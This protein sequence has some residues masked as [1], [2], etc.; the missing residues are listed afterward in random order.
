MK[1][2]EVRETL[3]QHQRRTVA[4]PEDL[5]RRA[6]TSSP[7]TS[8]HCVTS[9]LNSSPGWSFRSTIRANTISTVSGPL[10]HPASSCSPQDCEG[11]LNSAASTATARAP[12]SPGEEPF[13]ETALIIPLKPVGEFDH[14]N[15][16]L[17]ELHLYTNGT[18]LGPCLHSN[19]LRRRSRMPG[20]PG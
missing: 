4:L 5:S 2:N 1:S 8:L 14:P 13:A 18:Y 17:L 11:T 9:G 3:Q 6:N 15:D 20:A 7:L 12:E 16:H 19:S 10:S